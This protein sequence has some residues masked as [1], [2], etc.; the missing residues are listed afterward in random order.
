VQVDVLAQGLPDNNRWGQTDLNGVYYLPV[1]SGE[2]YDITVDFY[3]YGTQTAT[4]TVSSPGQTVTTDFSLAPLPEVAVSG[5]A[6][7]ASGHGYP[8]YA[9]LLF[10]TPT[11]SET[12]FTHPMT[13]SYAINL[14]QD[15]AYEITVVSEI[16]GYQALNLTE[17]TFTNASATRDFPLLIASNCSAPGYE[18]VSG[19]AEAFQQESQPAGWSVADH[20][21]SGVVWR[22]DNPADRVNLTGGADNFAII[23]SDYAGLVNI[24]SSLISPVVDMSGESNVTLSFDQDF[25]TWNEN[26]HN[27]VARVDVSKDGGGTWVNVLEQTSDVRGPNHQDIDISAVAAYQPDV[28]VRFHYYNANFEWWWQVDNV[29]IAPYACGLVQGGVMAG[30][31]REAMTGRPLNGVRIASTQAYTYSRPTLLDT[32]RPGGFYWL[33]QPMRADVQSVPFDVSLAPYYASSENVTLHRDAVTRQDFI[34][35]SSR[36]F[37]PLFRK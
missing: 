6:Y 28:R 8:L 34:L 20:A 2:T 11:H 9:V 3:G 13:G 23:D 35:E 24:N 30:Y 4:K 1:F 18:A 7:D 22:F 17:I 10:E 5:T 16:P 21:G 29:A 27:E 36:T 25:Y 33:F 32:Q 15:T 37:L 14:F 26:D 12:I 19:L 31:V